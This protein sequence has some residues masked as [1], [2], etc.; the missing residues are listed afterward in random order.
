M[1]TA[2]VPAIYHLSVRHTRLT[3]IRHAFGYR[4]YLWL[5][6]LDAL[7]RLPRW[8]RPLAAFRSADHAG[9][10]LRSIK[11]NVVTYCA[12]N[13]VDLTGGR[14]LMLAG[15]RVF[16]HV[17]N[18][19]TLLWCHDRSGRLA[20]LIA[21]VH[22]THG[23][24]HRYLLRPDAAG[25]STQAKTFEVSPFFDVSGEY[26]IRVSA[27]TERLSVSIGLRRGGHTAFV[28]T[29]RGTRRPGSTRE[30]LR[31]AVRYPW[32]TLATSARI[33]Y[34]GIRLW[35]RGLPIA[36]PHRRQDGRSEGRWNRGAP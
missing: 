20:A 26:R 16:G 6:D 30:L 31:C 23:G 27:P 14:V 28:A 24:R 19:L 2:A 5:V 21:E 25:R 32:S 3:P 13:G 4:T 15:A 36:A 11:A 7:P 10:P 35:L 1:T 12:E 22:N 34:Q 9:D 17:F 33:R 8:A 29:M 18:P